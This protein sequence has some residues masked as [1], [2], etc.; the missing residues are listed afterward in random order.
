M[1]LKTLT[2]LLTV[3]LFSQCTSKQQNNNDSQAD[4]VAST[5]TKVGQQAPTFIFY[6]LDG[7]AK[8][9]SEYKGKVVLIN[10]F[11][12]WCGSCMKEMPALEQEI[13]QAYKDKNFTILAIGREHKPEEM[14][15]FISQKG[16]TFPI[17]ADPDRSI[18]AKYANKYIP[19]NI[20]IDTEGKIAFQCVGY[21]KQE[22][23][24]LKKKIEELL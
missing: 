23:A 9:L 18:Y 16:Y 10:F 15:A 19:R 12:T 2:L 17:F 20:L 14:Q 4:Q 8:A 7:Q 3:A 1:K 22:F 24:K 5:L 13:W 21:E 6:T 11:A